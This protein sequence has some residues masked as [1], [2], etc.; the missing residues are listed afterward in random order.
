M[1]P[2]CRHADTRRNGGTGR[3]PVHEPDRSPVSAEVSIHLQ[4]EFPGYCRQPRCSAGES[5]ERPCCSIRVPAQNQ[6]TE[7]VWFERLPALVSLPSCVR[8]PIMHMQTVHH[9]LRA[10]RRRAIER[11]RPRPE[12]TKCGALADLRTQAS[13]IRRC[14][15]KVRD[16]LL[17]PWPVSTRAGM[18]NF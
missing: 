4:L 13:G 5:L 18:T 2:R 10:V 8:E 7:P 14:Q 11:Q 3:S 1:H 16:R 17:E 15:V 9:P 6:D 12:Q